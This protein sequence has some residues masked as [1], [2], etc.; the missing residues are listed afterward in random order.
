MNTTLKIVAISD[1][2]NRH[3]QLTIPECDILIS[4]GDYSFKGTESEVKNF[5]KWLNKQPA[6]HKI[7][8]QGNHELGVEANWDLS[9]AIALEECPDAHF[10]CHELVEVEG[11]KI[12]C[13]S[14]TPEFYDWAWNG[15]R[16]LTRSQ[17]KQI[18]YLRDKWVDIPQEVDI[19]ACHGP[20]FEILDA[21]Y[22][23]DGVTIKERVGCYHLLDRVLQT[24]AKIFMNGHIHG[25]HGYKF[26][27]DKQFYNVAICG[28]TY[29][30]DYK[31]TVIQF[32][33]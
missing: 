21:V 33:K 20:C 25:S 8:I 2:H 16:T 6:K 24:N 5:H 28:E 10:V 1:T 17:M 29:S 15:A 30:V 13:S 11:L 23:I 7:S 14:W 31:P 27:M 9:K 22:C 19:I 26:F 12:F 18:P 32:D 3:N 4:V